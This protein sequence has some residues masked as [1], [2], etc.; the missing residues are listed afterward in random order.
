MELKLRSRPFK[1][2]AFAAAATA[3]A[4]VVWG[5]SLRK[6]APNAPAPAVIE[7]LILPKTSRP[8][9]SS[10]SPQFERLEPANS[11]DQD[12]AEAAAGKEAAAPSGAPG[13]D[14]SEGGNLLSPWT[15]ATR[16][17]VREHDILDCRLSNSARE[18]NRRRQY[19]SDHA[20]SP[21]GDNNGQSVDRAS[22]YTRDIP[23]L[24]VSRPPDISRSRGQQQ[25]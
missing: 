21:D 13:S 9:A 4:C 10:S 18:W 12:L 11:A 25:E 24:D 2:V 1:V 3:N 16:S 15:V 14:G 8:A 20:S 23:H 19:C 7:V 22:Q 5:L 6:P 17:R